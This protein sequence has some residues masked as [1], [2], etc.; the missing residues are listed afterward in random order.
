MEYLIGTSGYDYADWI[1][2]DRFYPPSVAANRTDM[3]TYYASQFSLLELNFTHYGEASPKQLQLMLKRVD[4]TRTVY[5]ID[6]EFTP[7][8]D[9][10]FSIKAYRQLTHEIG[11][12]SEAYGRK[13]IG[14]ISPLRESG[15]LCAVL[16]QFPP[17]FR[18]TEEALDYLKKV[19]ELF[20]DLPIVYEFR[21]KRWFVSEAV[22]L[23]KELACAYCWIDAP[24]T[25]GL[26]R[27]FFPMTTDFAYVRLHGRNELDW[28]RG[29]GEGGAGSSARYHYS[30]PEEEI[31][32]L[33]QAIVDAGAKKGY[34]LFNNHPVADAP[35]NARQM[36]LTLE[37]LL[38]RP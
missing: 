12:E 13:F 29:G 35:K 1:G 7:K 33:A 36:E 23:L 4:P 25:A 5:L 16:F 27:H 14:D 11:E 31:R 28:W 8:T 22:D 15:K 6:R 17:S 10:Q 21:Y 32:Q 38:N 19:R 30:Y 26:P 3:L 9:F 24:R 18:P 20:H 2:E 37:K 34:I